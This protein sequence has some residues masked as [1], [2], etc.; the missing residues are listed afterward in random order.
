MRKKAGFHVYHWLLIRPTNLTRHYYY[1]SVFFLSNLEQTYMDIERAAITGYVKCIS[2]TT[3]PI[4]ITKDEIAN[5]PRRILT[6][7]LASAR[8]QVASTTSQN[9]D[10]RD[11]AYLSDTE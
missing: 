2:N 8:A 6:F 10:T 11:L 4:D 7:T 1:F 5:Q 3:T 9:L